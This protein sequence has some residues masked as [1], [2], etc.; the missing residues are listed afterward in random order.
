MVLA[1]ADQSKGQYGPTEYRWA[2]QAQTEDSV[3]DW[4]EEDHEKDWQEDDGREQDW[5]VVW[6]EEPCCCLEGSLPANPPAT[7]STTSC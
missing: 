4:W 6:R 1:E 7:R 5:Q 3:R 2:P